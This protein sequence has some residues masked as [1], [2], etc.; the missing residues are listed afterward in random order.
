MGDLRWSGGFFKGDK[1][2]FIG[3]VEAEDLAGRG[4]VTEHVEKDEKISAAAED[5]DLGQQEQ[6]VLVQKSGGRRQPG[7][8]HQGGHGRAEGVLPAPEGGAAG[9]VGG[10]SLPDDAEGDGG[11]MARGKETP[12]QP[13]DALVDDQ[14]DK[15]GGK[16]QKKLPSEEKVAARGE[17]GAVE[18]GGKGQEGEH[19]QDGQGDDVDDDDEAMV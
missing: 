18:P 3:V 2:A 10:Q 1:A 12:G 11:K 13:V 9:A 16:E 7:A 5:H 19:D 6:P 4:A 8:Q 17:A 15:E 14:Q